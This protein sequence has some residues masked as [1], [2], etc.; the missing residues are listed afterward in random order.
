MVAQAYFEWVHP[1]AAWRKS[2]W[3]WLARKRVW[4]TVVAGILGLAALGNWLEEEYEKK[5]RSG[6]QHSYGKP[7][8]SRAQR[9]G[10]QRGSGQ[11][12][13]SQRGSGCTAATAGP[14][15]SEAANCSS[16]TPAAAQLALPPSAQ[17]QKKPA[18]AGRAADALHADIAAAAAP[19]AAAAAATNTGPATSSPASYAGQMESILLT[20]KKTATKVPTASA[21]DIYLAT[22]PA[23]WPIAYAGH[24]IA[25][26]VQRRGCAR[27]GD[28][29]VFA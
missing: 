5:H 26:V 2:L 19:P 24:L 29:T 16:D 20:P 14:Q 22:C 23:L 4:I 9:S 28:V 18:D 15:A 6:G 10:S 11:R 21:G 7:A 25:Q 12:S 3:Q 13:G 27:L 8:G 1:H 17:R